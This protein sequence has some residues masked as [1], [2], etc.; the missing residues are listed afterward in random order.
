MPPT[1]STTKQAE[2]YRNYESTNRQEIVENLYKTKHANMTY[3]FSVAEA[4]KYLKLDK[5][6]MS[7]MEALE[8]LNEVVDDSDPDTDLPQ[9]VHAFQTAEEIRERF[10]DLDW[11]HLTGLI[12]DLGKMLC[13]PKMGGLPNW[14]M[15]GD[16]YP[17]GCKF[18]S[19][20]PFAK[21]FELNPDSSNPR[22]NTDL[23]IYEEGCGLEKVTFAWGHDEY[24]Y[25]VLKNCDHKL[26]AEA[27]YMVRFHSFYAWHTAGEYKHLCNDQD[28]AMMDWVKKFQGCDLYS[29]KPENFDIEKLRPYYQSLV[30]KYLPSSIQF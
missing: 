16:T 22:F 11:M 6:R 27:L 26:P 29:K 19:A 5:K 12:H 3:D 17:V 28:R 13:H 14:E 20:I 25:H 8:F 21:Y 1:G 18:S 10:P 23:G 4:A 15:V 2:E 7:I 9:I 30:D 24:M